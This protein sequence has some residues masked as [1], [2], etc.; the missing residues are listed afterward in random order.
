[1]LKY[2]SFHNN[3]SFALRYFLNVNGKAWLYMMMTYFFHNGLPRR[4]KPDL[5]SFEV[6]PQQSH[7][8]RHPVDVVLVGDVGTLC[9]THHA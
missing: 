4:F 9:L 8:N 5:D 2:L 3:S 1:M 6:C 7:N